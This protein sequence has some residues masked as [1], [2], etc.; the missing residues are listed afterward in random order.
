MDERLRRAHQ[1]RVATAVFNVTTPS[2]VLGSLDTAL[3]RMTF[4][5]PADR[6]PRD[7]VRAA[8]HSTAR[9]CTRSNIEPSYPRA[10]SLTSPIL[11]PR[12]NRCPTARAFARAEPPLSRATIRSRFPTSCGDDRRS[13]DPISGGVRAA[14]RRTASVAGYQPRT[15]ADRRSCRRCFAD[16]QCPPCRGGRRTPPSHA[17][18]RPSS[19]E[20]CRSFAQP[21]PRPDAGATPPTCGTCRRSRPTR[22]SSCTRPQHRVIHPR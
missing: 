5:P 19:K 13:V 20:R 3:E 15:V 7:E 17:L 8:G 9:C 22:S 2:R 4:R 10:M 16:Q 12:H 6:S 21:S 14:G 11:T 1:Q 18:R